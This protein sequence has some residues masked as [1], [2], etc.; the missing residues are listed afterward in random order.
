VVHR[1][2]VI[3]LAMLTGIAALF[4]TAAFATAGSRA[5][6]PPTP[7]PAWADA[8]QNGQLSDSGLEKA[9][10]YLKNKYGKYAGK[11]KKNP[12]RKVTSNKR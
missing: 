1:K 6:Q 7:G 10:N 11:V 4:Y 5:S 9:A 3:F 8:R 2:A 12:Q